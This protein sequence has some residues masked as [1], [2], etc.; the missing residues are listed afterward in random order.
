[1][2]I[3]AGELRGRKLGPTPP[4]VRPTGDRVREAIFARL[5]DLEALSVLDLFAGTGAMGLEAISRGADRLVAVDKSGRSIAA[6]RH[7][8]AL[9]GVGERVQIIKRDARGALR[10]L[11]QAGTHSFD[12]AFLDPPYAETDTLAAALAALVDHALLSP[13]AT[14]VVE[15][16]KRHAVAP[17]AGLRCEDTREYGDTSITWLSRVDGA[18]SPGGIPQS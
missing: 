16:P 7:N 3:I 4:G 17:V 18:V 14:V 5:G 1:M 11:A 6:V 13:G 2:R 10:Q 9:L 8:V 12:L 15:S